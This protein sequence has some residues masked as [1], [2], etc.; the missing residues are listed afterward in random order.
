MSND[1]VIDLTGG[2]A[3]PYSW[4]AVEI[5]RDEI[6]EIADQLEMMHDLLSDIA[7]ISLRDGNLHAALNLFGKDIL[8]KLQ[9]FHPDGR[10]FDSGYVNTVAGGRA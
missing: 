7:F 1:R 2:N 5:P 8:E 3:R 6:L 9:H 10:R 4:N